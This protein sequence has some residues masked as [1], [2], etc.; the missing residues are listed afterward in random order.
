MKPTTN[1]L[2]SAALLLTS[3]AIL[4]GCGGGGSGSGEST[5]AAPAAIKLTVIDTYGVAVA[6]A[7][8]EATIG[9]SSSTATTDTEGVA[10]V[11]FS[12]ISGNASVTKPA[13]PSS[14]R[15]LARWSRP[16]R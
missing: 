5:L 14:P 2:R 10:L 9:T 6:G 16:I 1:F 7:T 13:P 4:A 8:V 11:L 12:G 15:T 3:L